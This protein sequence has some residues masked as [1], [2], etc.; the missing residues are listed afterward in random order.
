[1]IR[2][3]PIARLPLGPGWGNAGPN[4]WTAT[5]ATRFTTTTTHRTRP[6]GIAGTVRTIKGCGARAACT[7]AALS[8]SYAIAACV[9]SAIR[10]RWGCG[11]P[12]RRATGARRRPIFE[13]QFVANREP[14]LL[15]AGIGRGRVIVEDE[16]PSPRACGESLR[17]R[18]SI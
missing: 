17:A 5:M 1:M 13:L 8:C 18:N 14:A 12:Y 10:F 3:R 15:L 2:R 7:L 4:G 11:G 6:P 16:G 9:S